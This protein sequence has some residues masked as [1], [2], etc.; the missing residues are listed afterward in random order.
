MRRFAIAAQSPAACDKGSQTRR[1]YN[2]TSTTSLSEE[3]KEQQLGPSIRA[4]SH[5]EMT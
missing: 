2:N 3:K 5:L 4:D 1:I